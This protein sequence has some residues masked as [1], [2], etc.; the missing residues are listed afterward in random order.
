MAKRAALILAG[1]QA[2]RF[3]VEHE[4][5]K[6]KALARLYGK[7]LLAHVVEAV[8]NVVDEIIICVNEETRKHRYSEALQEYSISNVKFCVD[9]E[10]LY[11]KGP[12]A[13]IATGLR[14]T[15]ADCCIVLSCDVPLMQPK[16]VDYLFNAVRDSCIAVPIWPDGRLESLI[17]TC[18]R[19]I[20][21][22]IAVM[23]CEL[24]RRRPDD[25]IRG[26]SR[27]T[28]VSTIGDLKNLD[29]E[30]KSFININLRNDLTRLPTRTI[31]DG[32]IKKSL[33]VNAGSPSTSELEQLKI[34]L[35]RHREKNFLGASKI[36]SSL[37]LQLEDRRLNFWSG[38]TREN[39][40]KSL[41]YLSEMQNDI[42]LKKDYYVKSEVAYMKAAG[43][44]RLEAEF[45]ERYQLN[46]LA[47]RALA[48]ELWSASRFSR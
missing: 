21:A 33:Q 4:H 45:Y 32:P 41:Y 46:F 37:S 1:G 36:F 16:V 5:W 26:A 13:A 31:K 43:N 42:E 34:A 35:K 20:T 29:P 15:N 30:F 17:I 18:E 19:P 44:Y 9:E 2:R 22:Q 11:V 25:I 12:M 28:F 8:K 14:S 38:I 3:Q 47:K 10:F 27:V 23:L 48:D 7:P 40:G 24:G 39:E 6:D